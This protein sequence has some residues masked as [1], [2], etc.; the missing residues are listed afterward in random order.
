M[1]SQAC[2]NVLLFP[3]QI[4]KQ[5]HR[6]KCS[7]QFTV[8]K[9]DTGCSEHLHGRNT[10]TSVNESVLHARPQAFFMVF[11]EGRGGK[12]N[13]IAP[14]YGWGSTAPRL[15]PFRG[16]SLLFTTKFPEISGTHFIDLGRMKGWVDF[17]ATQWSVVLNTGP[18]DWQSCALTITPLLHKTN[19]G[20]LIE[21]A[22]DG[23][24]DGI[25]IEWDRDIDVLVTVF[26]PSHFGREECC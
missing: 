14:F 21:W 2:N 6:I 22:R 1:T 18:L 8:N 19:D 3:L 17:E 11:T 24:S 20:I 23:R 12:K 26:P 7:D 5:P 9:R 16:G 25:L 13:F 4:W 15:Q 10:K